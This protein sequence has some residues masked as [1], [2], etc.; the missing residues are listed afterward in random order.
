[1]SSILKALRKLEEEKSAQQEGSV[2]IARDILRL[3]LRR[4]NSKRSWLLPAGA[5]VFLLSAV[6]ALAFFLPQGKEPLS[7]APVAP[8]LQAAPSPA[9]SLPAVSPSVP[10]A[11]TAPPPS[12]A[13][14]VVPSAPSRRSTGSLKNV[15]AEETV[16]EVSVDNPS[17]PSLAESS[18]PKERKKQPAASGKSSRPS[19]PPLPPL[20]KGE[21]FSSV[22]PKSEP[23]FRLSGIA[24]QDD[25]E[26]RVAVVNDLPVMKGTSIEGAMVQEI[27]PDRVRLAL[28]GGGAL[29]LFLEP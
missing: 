15:P 20:P 25:P 16:V 17:L 23:S 27:L 6:I 12:R 8:G 13:Q 4:R 22:A 1:M 19:V 11:H 7:T 10:A 29:D 5:A 24:Y 26:A 28:P 14:E 2:D 9:I 18:P 3:P 21:R